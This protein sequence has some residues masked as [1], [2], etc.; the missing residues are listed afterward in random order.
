[1]LKEKGLLDKIYENVKKSSKI[2]QD[3]KTS[4]SVFA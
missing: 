2:G 1:M 4:K 3:K